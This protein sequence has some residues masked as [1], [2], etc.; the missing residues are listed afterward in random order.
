MTR[1]FQTAQSTGFRTCSVMLINSFTM[2]RTCTVCAHPSRETID[3]SLV[4]GESLRSIAGRY[5]VST[6]ALHRHKQNDLP[7]VLQR[8]YEDSEQVRA[9]S[10]VLEIEEQLAIGKDIQSRAM[11]NDD[12]RLGLSA[13]RETR[14]LLSLLGKA[15]GELPAQPETTA[16]VKVF[17]IDTLPSLEALPPPPDSPLPEEMRGLTGDSVK[18]EEGQCPGNRQKST[19]L[20]TVSHRRRR[21]PVTFVGSCWDRTNEQL[22]RTGTELIELTIRLGV[23]PPPVPPD[24][25]LPSFDPYIYLEI[26]TAKW[27]PRLFRY[28]TLKML[29]SMF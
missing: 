13:I 7:E 25:S 22:E 28:G 19:V 17:R 27:M 8:A 18:Q 20:K 5:D 15:R 29:L 14:G 2:P 10:L 6:S 24:G 11:A 26:P 12:L 1:I 9:K 16:P 23:P 4:H 21:K 3:R